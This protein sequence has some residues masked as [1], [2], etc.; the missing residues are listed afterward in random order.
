MSKLK[1]VSKL[2]V[3]TVDSIVN[4]CNLKDEKLPNISVGS[5]SVEQNNEIQVESK[6]DGNTV[7]DQCGF[8]RTRKL[9][10]QLVLSGRLQEPPS[11]Q[12]PTGQG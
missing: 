12:H 5:F 7:P 8:N 2:Q 4:S 10:Q 9:R 1:E 11:E 6:F 3:N